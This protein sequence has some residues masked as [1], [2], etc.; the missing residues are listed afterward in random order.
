MVRTD[1]RLAVISSNVT[2][3]QASTLPVAGLTALYSLGKAGSLLNKRIL[4][5]GSTGGVG[6]FAHQ[7]ATAA[8]VYVVGVTRRKEQHAVVKRAGANEVILESEL[9]TTEAFGPYDLILDSVG[10]Q[11][12]ADVLKHLPSGGTCV[13]LGYSSSPETMI[14]LRE[15]IHKGRTKVHGFFLLEELKHQDLSKDL[16]SLANRIAKGQHETNIAVEDSW[17]N[18]GMIAKKLI[19]R[20][21]YGKA[22]LHIDD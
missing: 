9:S 15:L 16:G 5:T 22:V 1:N 2:F 11:T 21:Y 17:N 18:I 7:L 12:F 13:T 14:D 20:K 6:L 10:G 3:A 8:G 19:E 4:I